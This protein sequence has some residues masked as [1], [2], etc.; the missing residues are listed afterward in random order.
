[1]QLFFHANNPEFLYSVNFICRNVILKRS[2]KDTAV[3]T[4]SAL[5]FY[6]DLG[7]LSRNQKKQCWSC[8]CYIRSKMSVTSLSYY[9]KKIS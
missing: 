7:F 1:L 8:G 6:L 3:Q 9:C 4:A 5:S 2:T